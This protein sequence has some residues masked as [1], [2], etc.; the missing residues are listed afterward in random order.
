MTTDISPARADRL[1]AEDELA[2]FRERFV[3]I[4][5]PGVVAYL[6]GNSLGRPLRATA[7]RLRELVEHEW[8]GRLIRAW[9]ERWLALPEELGDELGRVALGAAPGQTIV[10]D[11]TS[12]CLYKTLRAAAALRPGRDEIVTDTAN[13]PTDRFLVESVAAELGLTVRWAESEDVAAVAGPRTA[14]V[15]LSHVDYRTAAIT[16]LAAVTRVVHEHGGLV[17]WDLCHSVGSLPVELD[18]A[19]ADFAVGCTYKFLNAGPGAPA[20]LYAN[21][22][23]HAA[24]GQPVTGWMG[25][26]DTFGMAAEYVPAPGIRRALSGTPPVLGMVGVQEG[27]ALLAEAG[28]G[29]VRAKA[30]AL[31]RWVLALADAWLVPLGF[32]IASPRDDDRRGGHVT[33]RHPDAERLS[34]VLIEHGVLIDFRRPDGIRIGLSPLTT[35]FAEVRRAMD[36]IRELAG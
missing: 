10:A 22:R 13:F 17:V 8:G 36:R 29:R 21:A 27:V 25:A 11:S 31:G 32:T 2:A 4:G 6:D 7:E 24:F 33:L 23:H 15:T 1:D 19:G 35:G 3:P 14:V 9:E 26:A 5:D 12:V 16:D 34:H 20:F 30:V 18:A 28:I